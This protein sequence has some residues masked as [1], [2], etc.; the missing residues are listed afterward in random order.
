MNDVLEFIRGPLFAATFAFMVLGLLRRVVLQA[1]QLRASLRRLL[2]P[3][4]R[5]WDNLRRF[6]E[7]LVP[8]KHI[9]RNRWLL[10]G[11]SFLFHVGLLIVP[12][13][14]AAHVALWGRGIGLSWPAL[15]PLL[16]DLATLTVIAAGLVLLGYRLFDAG[17]REL[18]SASD[19]LLLL[20]LLVPFVSGW[21]ALHPAM[22]PFS[23]KAVML[24]HVLGA[25]LVFVLLPTTKLAH[26]VLF[27]FVRVS[28]DVFWKM[29]PGAGDL[30]ARELHGEEARV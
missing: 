9:Y 24:V 3:E 12:L 16:A 21:L 28:S 5:I 26:C 10:S 20:A 17:A 4:L 29:P 14:L 15:P 19:Y 22:S 25:E 7:W 23:Y 11:A 8:V 2:G 18:S 27:P 6:M 13:F 30:V 1:T